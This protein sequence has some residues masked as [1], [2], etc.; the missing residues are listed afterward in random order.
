[1]CLEREA[2]ARP[3][4]CCNLLRGLAQAAPSGMWHCPG[5]HHAPPRLGL[6]EGQ[7]EVPG[8]PTEVLP[9]GSDPQASLCPSS[10][11]QAP[12][13]GSI[14]GFAAR[15]FHQSVRFTKGVEDRKISRKIKV[16]FN[17]AQCTDKSLPGREKGG[18]PTVL[19]AV[20]LSQ[21]SG[22]MQRTTARQNSAAHTRCIGNLG[23]ERH[24]ALS[25]RTSSSS[26]CSPGPVG[27]S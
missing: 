13:R 23:W 9:G 25:N 24:F 1:M 4:S 16:H 6:W 22:A 27:L 5:G 10:A 7:P 18:K 21:G 19:Q 17:Q 12:G 14:W 3:G 2:P 15:G 26:P 11:T 20:F 8:A